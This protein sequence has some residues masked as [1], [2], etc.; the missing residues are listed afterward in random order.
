MEEGLEIAYI[1]FKLNQTRF[2]LGEVDN[3]VDLGK[4]FLTTPTYQFDKLLSLLVA[5][6]LPALQVVRRNP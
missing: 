2:N 3:I 5:Y 1:R 6:A 4:Q